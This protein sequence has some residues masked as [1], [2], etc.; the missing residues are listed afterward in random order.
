VTDGAWRTEPTELDRIAPLRARVSEGAR[1]QIVRYSILPRGLAQPWALL[2]DDEIAGYAGVWADHFPGRIMEL[3]LLP[4]HA[5]HAARLLRELV[6]VSGA[7]EIEWQSNLP[8]MAGIAESVA[9]DVRTEHLLFCEPPAL[10]ADPVGDRERPRPNGAEVVRR[11]DVPEREGDPEGPW[12][13]VHDGRIVAA[14]GILTHYNAPYGDLYMAV[15]EDARRRGFGSFLVRELRRVALAQGLVP[16]A[17]CG[18]ANEASRRTLVR[19]GLQE[20]GRLL[21]GRI[22]I[23]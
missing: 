7:G 23:G 15:A 20:C 10:D 8:A 11:E 22:R 12:V 6:R 5:V 9:T 16:S 17:R 1:C 3:F 13:V 2:F 19:A 21:S 4:E 18:P 14:G